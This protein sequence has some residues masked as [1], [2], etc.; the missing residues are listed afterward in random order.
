MDEAV[1]ARVEQQRVELEDQVATLKKSLRHWQVLET[2]YEGIK[3]EVEL[4]GTTSPVEESYNAAARFP[5]GFV[6]EAELRSLFGQDK[7]IYRSPGQVIDILSR[8]IDYSLE[9]VSIIKKKLSDAEKKRNALLLAE[10]P[11]YRDEAGLPLMEITEE[12]DPAGNVLSGRA[13]KPL[14]GASRLLKTLKKAGVK[15]LKDEDGQIKASEGDADH[16]VRPDVEGEWGNQDHTTKAIGNT[17]ADVKDLSSQLAS[18]SI[19]HIE[20]STQTAEEADVSSQSANS[21]GDS[22]SDGHTDSTK[23]SATEEPEAGEINRENI[24]YALTEIGPIVAQLD[25]E[26]ERSDMSHTDDEV[27]TLFM[28]SNIDDDMDDDEEDESEDEDGM[29]KRPVIS[30]KYR[31]QME[32]LEKKLN[33]KVMHV[34]GP[35]PALPADMEAD[36]NK[37]APAEAARNAAIARAEAASADASTTDAMPVTANK[38]SQKSKKKVAFADSLD[39]TPETASTT[40]SEQSADAKS[41][42]AAPGPVSEAVLERSPTTSTD[43]TSQKGPGPAKKMF[44]FKS[45]RAS[46]STSDTAAAPPSKPAPSSTD[47]RIFSNSI[48]ENET[49]TS[50][51]A[52]DPVKIDETLQQRQMATEYHRLRTKMIQQQGG[53]VG[54]GSGDNYGEPTAPLEVIDEDTGKV[55]KISRFKAARLK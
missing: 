12:L 4:A 19:Q 30:D 34:V 35:D 54:D 16:S 6:D 27:E 49:S 18:N 53:F 41:F 29:T 22:S 26:E 28:E 48:L 25:L 31:R 51:P 14:K 46:Q 9:N 10:E 5:A 15:G 55:K 13:H 21:D 47:G 17:A 40:T 24:D 23:L 52:P 45:D 20:T 32:E 1:L 43:P 36:L 42:S 7:G 33:L 11:D 8:R 37:L 38:A 2:D 39:I 44:R 50:T 3:E